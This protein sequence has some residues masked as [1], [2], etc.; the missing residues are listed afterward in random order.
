MMTALFSC[1]Y[2][3]LY[4]H[5]CQPRLSL[6]ASARAPVHSIKFDMNLNYEEILYK[7]SELISYID[8][9]C[10]KLRRWHPEMYHVQRWTIFIDSYPTFFVSVTNITIKYDEYSE[11]NINK[12]II[13]Q[14][15][16]LIRK[17]NLLYSYNQCVYLWSDNLYRKRLRPFL[18]QSDWVGIV[19]RGRQIHVYDDQTHLIK[20]ST[21][22]RHRYSFLSHTSTPLPRNGSFYW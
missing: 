18:I 13:W 17:S 22:L 4:V 14:Y 7:L 20:L 21:P 6:V 1:Q 11:S 16:K 9:L 12:K 19:M 2:P 10:R 5:R 8:V 15:S 3:I